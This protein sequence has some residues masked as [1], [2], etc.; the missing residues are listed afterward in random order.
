MSRYFAAFVIVKMPFVSIAK[1]EKR[2]K[3][4]RIFTFLFLLLSP[5]SGG[6]VNDWDQYFNVPP[7]HPITNPKGLLF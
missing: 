2:S 4:M 1:A 7:M 3:N 5:S 6:L